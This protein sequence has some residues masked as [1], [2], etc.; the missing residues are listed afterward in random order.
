MATYLIDYENVHD[1]GLSGI[2]KLSKTDSVIIFI[3]NMKND[4]PIET[5]MTMFNSQAQIVIKKLNKTADN[6]LDFQLATCL[7][8]LITSGEDRDFYIISKDRD[9]EAVI[10]YWKDNN[11]RVIVERR[12]SI[13]PPGQVAVTEAKSNKLRAA[14]K[15]AIRRL[16]K[17][18]KLGQAHYAEIYK[19]FLNESETNLLQSGLVKVFNQK[20]GSRLY[21]LLKDAFE[22]HK[23]GGY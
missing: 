2:M 13:L 9:Y 18:E 19:L 5:V 22:V 3:G 8:G 1:G 14:T 4:L 12:T 7:G 23:A 10:D 15:K 20:K 21:E 16:V 6:Y 17:D 11:A